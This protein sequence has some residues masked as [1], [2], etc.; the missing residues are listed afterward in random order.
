MINTID[1]RT[2][3]VIAN[4][5]AF[6]DSWPFTAAMI[7]TEIAKQLGAGNIHMKFD[8][9]DELWHA[10]YKTMVS[11]QDQALDWERQ[12]QKTKLSTERNQNA[13]AH[14]GKR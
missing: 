4:C 1:F 10:I 5:P 14:T 11:F 6:K 2:A 13:C 7:H 9:E 8:S 3:N 12:I